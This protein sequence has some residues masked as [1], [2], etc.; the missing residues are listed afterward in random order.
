MTPFRLTIAAALAAALSIPTLLF[1]QSGKLLTGK[2]AFTDWQGETPGIRRVIKP[3]DLP[4]PFATESARNSTQL[5]AEPA[6][7]QPKT[8]PGFEVTLFAKGLSNPRL[9]RTA[10]NGDIFVAESAA[11]RIR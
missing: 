7:R 9:M 6:G 4:P 8:L 2:A 1:A 3:Q 10:P 11:G 5:V